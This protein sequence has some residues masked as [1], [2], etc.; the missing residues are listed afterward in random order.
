MEEP[1]LKVG[2]CAAKNIS[3]NLL[4]EYY[5][6]NIGTT[7]FGRYFL[8]FNNDS[9]ELLDSGD[10]LI[11]KGE[12]ISF[13][14]SIKKENTFEI[15]D[16]IIGINFHW[17]KK[18]RQ[19]FNGNIKFII[20]NDSLRAINTVKI[21]DYLLSVISSEMNATAPV[22]YLKSHAIISRSWVLSRIASENQKDMHFIENDE[23]RIKW[24]G[25]EEHINFDVC[26]DDHCQRYQ[27][28]TR[29]CTSAVKDAIDETRGIV[30]YSNNAICDARFSKCCG[31]VSENF[32]NV[33]EDE[34]IEYLSTII[35]S[36]DQSTVLD[37]RKE[38]DARK[39]I[40]Y[41]SDSFCNVK[42]KTLLSKILNDYDYSTSNFYRWEIEYSQEELSNLLLERSG[43]DFGEIK[44][45]I[46]LKRGA[47]GRIYELQ[48]DG[49]KKT[50]IFGKE[51]EI[52]KVLSKSH[53]YSSAFI[54]DYKK[55]KRDIPQVFIFKGSGWGHGVGLCQI[56]AASMIDKGYNHEEVLKHYFNKSE[57]K[58]IY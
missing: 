18:E 30:L 44:R 1:Q 58:R 22:E 47:S 56:G 26:A 54:V 15:E 57:L 41:E 16:V 8:R 50:F 10:N 29:A 28:I 25:R 37:L 5:I 36:E 31:G 21:E 35:D 11:Y 12:E 13:H 9:V 38:D 4:N 52:R 2:I 51:L 46:P 45:I 3:I 48:V 27:G 24:Y 53:L 33:W 39:W 14:P 23:K 17:E 20:E 32:E 43:I 49:T 19:K 6:K 40:T 34:K 55:I 7:L 42:D